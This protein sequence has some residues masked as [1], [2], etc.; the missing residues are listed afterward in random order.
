[1]NIF[2]RIAAGVRTAIQPPVAKAFDPAFTIIN[3]TIAKGDAS[4]TDPYSQSPWV[5]AAVRALGRYTASVPIVIRTGSK[6]G[7]EGDAVADSDPWQRLFDKPSP[8]MSTYAL[9][10]GISSYLDIHGE[11]FIVA[12]GE[13]AAPFKKG[14]IPRELMLV[15]PAYVTVDVDKRSSLVLGYTYQGPQGGQVA[16]A[17]DSV[18]HIKTFNPNDPTRGLS[19][20]QSVLLSLGFDV[21]AT[22]YNNALLSNGADPGGILYSDTPLDV[23]EVE[24]L[25][26]QWEDRHRGAIRA[27]RLAI[28]SGG[29]KYEQSKTTPKDMA[30]KEF[31]DLHREQILA[32]L[33]VNP[34]DVAQTPEYNRAAALAARAQTWEN[35]VVPRLR[36]IEDAF[37]SWLFEPYSVKQTRDT[38]LT[39]DLTGIEALQPNMTE[40]LQQANSLSMLGYTADQI[41]ERLDLGMPEAPADVLDVV[42]DETPAGAEPIVSDAT[43]VAETAMNGAQVT[44]LV[45]IVQSVAEGTLP[46]DSA[47]AMLLIAFPTISE[48]EARALIEPAAASTPTQA[49]PPPAPVPSDSTPPPEPEQRGVLHRHEICKAIGK[50][51]PRQVR[52]VRRKVQQLQQDHAKE[53]LKRLRDL[54]QFKAVGDL[55]ELT[56]AELNKILGTPKEWREAAEEYLKGVLDPVATY[57]LNSA[58]TQ[59]GGFE[60]VDIRDPKWYAKAASQT[61]SMV[62]VE[63]N[64]REAFRSALVDVFRTA[65]AGDIN[66]ISRTLEAKF[67]SEIPSNAD[68]VARTESAMLIQNVKETAATD[69][70]FTHKT[71]TTAGD[72]AV[73][74]SHAAIDNETVP[75]SD[76]FSNGL[77]YPSQMGGPPEEV[78]N[79]RCD[80]VYR[81]ID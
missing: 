23:S 38:W 44:S 12:F 7:G 34:F 51:L 59:F 15:N 78:I 4:V 25:R 52:N 49:P 31:M 11:A 54:P 42:A 65:G 61:A 17:A 50:Q 1:M 62:K 56:E 3:Q 19:P 9:L 27:A 26:A 22:A 48:E 45:E 20:I 16:F 68:T 21:K 77:M 64:R 81:V 37:W 33:G 14:Q 57:A 69:E 73:R 13:G 46:A 67:S 72:L 39:F 28:L 75:I 76:K 10:E 60:I 47:I 80:V 2:Q 18:C 8:L 29:L 66:E 53:I 71:W 58:K 41:N 74:A 40:K 32:V 63:T 35:T 70:G 5:Y 36:Q 30:F 79:C 43:S 55:P 6:R 24:A